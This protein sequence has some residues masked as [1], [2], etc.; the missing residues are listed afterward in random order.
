MRRLQGEFR[1]GDGRY[2]CPLTVTDQALRMIRLAEAI[3]STRE[4]PTIEAFVR[5]F[6]ERGLPADA[7]PCPHGQPSLV[8]FQFL[9]SG[10]L[11]GRRRNP[12]SAPTR[13]PGPSGECCRRSRDVGPVSTSFARPEISRGA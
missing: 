4:M 3:E 10:D 7:A 5:L 8:C 1:L 13:G 6:Q 12:I 2:C 9:V 11:T